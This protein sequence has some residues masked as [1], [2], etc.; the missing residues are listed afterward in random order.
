MDKKVSVGILT[1]HRAYNNGAYLQACALCNRLNE[2]SELVA[3]VIDFQ[4]ENEKTHYDITGNSVIWK[5]KRI[6]Q[7]KYFLL[8]KQMHAYDR[9]I[10]DPIMKRSKEYLRSNS[11]ETFEK[12]VKGKYDVIVVGSDEVWK[13][14]NFRGFPNPYWLIG[15]LNCKKF[16]YAASARV[17]FRKVLPSEKLA[18]LE[19]AIKDFDFISVRDEKTKG[20]LEELKA[21][22]LTIHKCCDPSFVYD[23]NISQINAIE[24][25]KRE[26]K[27]KN[28]KKTVVVIVGKKEIAE[29]IRKDLGKDF[30]ILALTYYHK[31]YINVANITPLEWLSIIRDADF[32]ISS[33]FHAA[34]FSI[35]QK[36]P[37][38]SV[39][40]RRMVDSKLDELLDDELLRERYISDW[41]CVEDFSILIRDLFLCYGFEEF[42]NKKRKSFQVFLDALKEQCLSKV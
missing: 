39:E 9:A 4:T 11:I 3:E 37:F 32:V 16:S 41:T 28:D 18:I 36:T 29:K 19:N 26:S 31:G 40:E 13:V 23:F 17:E 25:V 42:A 22:N 30:N 35:V 10:N 2:E 14:N 8:R 38:I 24:K 12:F 1:Y 21:T 15:D 33:L 34:C 27:F 20:E 7:R 6:I 5:T